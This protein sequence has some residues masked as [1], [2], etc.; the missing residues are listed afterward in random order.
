MVANTARYDSHAEWYV[1]CTQ[2]WDSSA[3]A[4]LPAELPGQAVLDLAC[5]WGQ[6][7]RIM[8]GRGAAVTG[9]DLAQRF[10][11]HARELETAQPAGIRYLVGNATSNDWWDGEP[12][13]GAVCNMAL[14]DIDDLAGAMSTVARVLK[15]SGWFVFT[16][17]HPCFPGNPEDPGSRPSWPPGQGYSAEGW[18]TTRESGVRGHVGANH[19]MLSTYLNAA[20]E[21]GLEFEGFAEARTELP[22]LFVAHCRRPASSIS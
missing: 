4:F 3:A 16:V 7:S 11:A 2:D 21:A 14:M 17:F 22:Q 5:G 10:I 13:D 1:E 20:L 15:P 12:F 9:V 19:R 18:W 8:A 6:L